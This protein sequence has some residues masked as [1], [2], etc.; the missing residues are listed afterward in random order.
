MALTRQNT[1]AY[2]APRPESGDPQLLALKVPPHSI[3]AEQSQALARRSRMFK[4]TGRCCC[5]SAG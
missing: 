4:T 5:S 1:A 2:A 3:E